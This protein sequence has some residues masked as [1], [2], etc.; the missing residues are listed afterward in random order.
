MGQAAC[1]ELLSFFRQE[2]WLILAIQEKFSTRTAIKNAMKLVINSNRT[3]SLMAVICATT[4][5]YL[6][7]RC[8][9]FRANRVRGKTS[10]VVFPKCSKLLLSQVEQG[11][12]VYSNLLQTCNFGHLSATA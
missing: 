8:D 5:E 3:F 12:R 11:T 4:W 2:P 9:C 7:R 6:K 10:A 1:S